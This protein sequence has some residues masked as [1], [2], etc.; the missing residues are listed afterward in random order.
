MRI[1]SSWG[2]SWLVKASCLAV[3]FLFLFRVSTAAA[4]P[5]E[6][7]SFG[8]FGSEGVEGAAFTPR[9]ERMA[10]DQS[11]RDL[12]VVQAKCLVRFH[13]T[14]AGVPVKPKEFPATGSDS[15]CFS[16]DILDVAVDNSSTTSAHRIYVAVSG[17]IFAFDEE[18]NAVG[19]AFPLMVAPTSIAVDGLG[20]LWESTSNSGGEETTVHEYSSSGAL[21]ATPISGGTHRALEL[22]FDS[23]DNLYIEV[24]EGGGGGAGGEVVRY[25]QA[26][27][28]AVPTTVLPVQP[29]VAYSAMAIDRASDH[30]FVRREVE[31]TNRVVVEY[32]V[33]GSGPEFPQVGPPFATESESF[34]NVRGMTVDEVAGIFYLNTDGVANGVHSFSRYG[35]HPEVAT[36]AAANVTNVAAT[37]SGT[38]NPEGVETECDFEYGLDSSYGSIAPCSSTPGTGE[39]PVEVYADLTGLKSSTV[40]HYRLVGRN[41]IG[42]VPGQDAQ[43][44]TFG[45]PSISNAGFDDATTTEASV[46][47]RINPANQVTKYRV[48]YISEAAYEANAPADEVQA[49]SIS[50][51]GGSFTLSFE[52]QE[53]GPIPFD[54]N[55]VQVE[56]QLN[57]LS[58]VGDVGGSVS[59]GGGPGDAG[60]S[61]PYEIVFG[62][63]LGGE[64]LPL[65]AVDDSGLTGGSGSNIET[66]VQGHSRFAGATQIPV[67]DG[68]IAAGTQEVAVTRR[69]SG[70]TPDSAYRFRFVA[71]N[72][73][74]TARGQALTLHTY[75]SSPPRACPNDVFRVGPSAGLPDCRAYEL[76]SGEGHG[77]IP[78]EA[79]LGGHG[80]GFGTELASPDGTS[81]IFTLG[82]GSLPGTEGN[83]SHDRYEALRGPGG[84]ARR[85]IS[86]SGAE[87][88]IPITGGASPDHGF[89]IWG[90]EAGLGGSFDLFP[91]GTVYLRRPDGGFELLGQG[92]PGFESYFPAQAKLVSPNGSHAIFATGEGSFG[93]AVQL[94]PDAPPSGTDAIYDRTL[95]GL[96][97]ISLLP[98]NEPLQAGEDAEYLGV[99]ADGSA[100]AFKLAGKSPLYLR[101]DDQRT[102]QVVANGATFAG[103]SADGKRLIYLKGGNVFSYDTADEEVT[104]ATSKAEAT[105]V[106]VSADG[107]H[108]YFVSP[109]LLGEAGQ[110]TLGAANLYVWSEGSATTEFVATLDPADLSGTVSLGNWLSDSLSTD[111]DGEH[112]PANN[113]SRITPDGSAFVFQSRARLTSYDNAGHTEV[114]RFQQGATGVLC[115]SCSPVGARAVSNAELQSPFEAGPL[116]A[117]AL[118]NNLSDDG[119]RAFFETADPLASED[120]DGVT[121]VYE[122]EAPGEGSCELSVGCIFLISSGQST[123]DQRLT[124]GNYLYAATPNGDDV[125]LRSNDELTPGDAKGNDAAL[126]DARVHGGFPVTPQPAC[127]LGEPCPGPGTAGPN[128]GQPGS[129]TFVGP[130]NAASSPRHCSPS[131]RRARRHGKTVCLKR[132]KKHNRHQ[133][134]HGNHRSASR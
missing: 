58:S 70:L 89:A 53:T 9:A 130:G 92:D 28:Y 129:A 74:G 44:S 69:I 59:V 107:S 101:I 34:Q 115:L 77:L 61:T 76:V 15:I 31:N 51:T 22:E 13:T 67:P 93:P 91:R 94:S 41:S 37:L 32:N 56:A 118:I 131:K 57:Q 45:P 33:V 85:L 119:D 100:V 42:S 124:T 65:L 63:A 54:A 114:Y 60:G 123:E 68:E 103:L 21:I 36:G 127:H 98:G 52:G 117:D 23:K 18:G 10:F 46:S 25:S 113:P 90:V 7:I 17:S 108:V 121:D 105:I 88:T 73:S 1:G 81:A 96:R 26:E 8:S 47:A 109:K 38:I 110:G 43:F 66:T 78:T 62:G 29:Q 27:G 99:S 132:H 71:S 72:V 83:G 104:Q 20:H 24:Q 39:G 75:V 19:G 133:R 11:N 55:A 97:V 16:A 49:L 12:L 106:N 86:P 111:Q 112:G 4:S 116:S 48:E 3:A 134:R 6:R 120:R 84:W 125:F 82:G 2:T 64:D 122:W 126:Y 30:L 80:T 5:E 79:G 102:L 14:D 87:A 50:A 35:I 95:A 128:I 40:Y